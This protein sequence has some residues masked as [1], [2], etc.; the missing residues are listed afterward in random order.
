MFI[1]IHLLYYISYNFHYYGTI[2]TFKLVMVCTEIL[3]SLISHFSNL[4]MLVL[5]FQTL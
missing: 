2:V 1:I 5:T 4:K 3:A